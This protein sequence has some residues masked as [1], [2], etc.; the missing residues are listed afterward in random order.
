MTT[1]QVIDRDDSVDGLMSEFTSYGEAGNLIDKLNTPSIYGRY[2]VN[3][4]ESETL[5]TL[6]E[7]AKAD[8]IT[9]KAAPRKPP[10]RETSKFARWFHV[11]L[12]RDT[13]KTFAFDCGFGSALPDPDV[14][15]AL[16]I[17]LSDSN[18]TENTYEQYI[19]D[20]GL[21][22]NPGQR[23]EWRQ[24][25]KRT[26]LFGQFIGDDRYPAYEDAYAATNQ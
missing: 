6:A 26:E 12:I 2:Y 17:L 23:S 20:Y 8:G 9:I 18:L 16:E 19:T 25:E 15:S 5:P 11:K 4:I 22:D 21:E 1:Y 7:L 3:T 13:R 10:R 24:L 14:A